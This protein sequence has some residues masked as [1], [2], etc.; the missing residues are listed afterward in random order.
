MGKLISNPEQL[1]EM[2]RTIKRQL[3]IN[4]DS[5]HI[6]IVLD[7][8]GRKIKAISFG[9]PHIVS[10]SEV[11]FPFGKH[12]NYPEFDNKP[13]ILNSDESY[14]LD[15]DEVALLLGIDYHPDNEI[16]DINAALEACVGGPGLANAYVLGLNYRGVHKNKNFVVIPVQYYQISREMHENLG[17]EHSSPDGLERMLKKL[18]SR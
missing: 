3:Y 1:V 4:F 2:N 11:E 16:I 14:F 12:P 9:I 13:Y 10:A 7:S 5:K 15:K 18:K 6:P 8:F 17:I